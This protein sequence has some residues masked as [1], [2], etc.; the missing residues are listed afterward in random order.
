MNKYD[1]VI[2]RGHTD[3]GVDAST[4]QLVLNDHDDDSKHAHDK[5]VVTD[6]LSLLEQ[7]LP[8]SQPVAYV[9]LVFTTSVEAPTGAQTAPLTDQTTTQ[10][11]LFC[12]LGVLRVDAHQCDARLFL[13]ALAGPSL[14]RSRD[15]QRRDWLPELKQ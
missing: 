7:S 12:V 14:H 8:A 6:P 3:L 5:G 11:P 4:A 10:R 1:D 9:G 15:G 2:Y 13:A